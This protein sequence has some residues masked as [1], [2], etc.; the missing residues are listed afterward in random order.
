[1]STSAHSNEASA[2]EVHQARDPG[3][4][5]EVT[6]V[7]YIGGA[8]RSGSTVLALLLGN[9]PGFVPIGGLNHLWERGLQKNYLCGCGVHFRECPFW[10]GVGREAFGGWDALDVNEIVRLKSEVTRYRHWPWH[11][12][13]RL[14]PAFSSELVAYSDYLA[15]LYKAVKSISGCRVIVDNSH[16][17]IPALLLQ[18]M[19]GVRGHIL[20][21]VRDSRGVAFSLS[22]RARRSEAK[23]TPMYMD[24]YSAAQA[25][26]VWLAGNLSYY[27]LWTSS[28]PKLRLSYEMLVTSP[29]AE[30]ER[31]AEFIGSELSASDLSVFDSDSI[32]ISENHMI[33][34][35]PHRLGR[36]EIQLRL[37]EEWR[38]KMRPRDRIVVSLLTFPV[39]LAYGY[40]RI[41]RSTN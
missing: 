33:S 9:V 40:L 20:H 7:A 3:P 28:L 5:P 34:G 36:K 12:A 18:R 8:G 13:P 17:L 11:L 41:G 16:D 14:R 35:N 10:E 37:D 29:A 24:Q 19:R 38:A 25:S 22:K 27:T 32:G 4:E 26:I 6:D 21:L 15:R 23:T 30:I 39:I 2:P 1:L 31:I